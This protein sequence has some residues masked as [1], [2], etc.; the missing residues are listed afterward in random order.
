MI[1]PIE[2]KVTPDILNYSEAMKNGK[3]RQFR[4]R[5][6]ELACWWLRMRTDVWREWTEGWNVK[7]EIIIGGMFTFTGTEEF[8][9]LTPIKEP[10]NVSL[11]SLFPVTPLLLDQKLINLNNQ[12]QLMEMATPVYVDDRIK[13]DNDPE[14]LDGRLG[15]SEPPDPEL[16]SFSADAFHAVDQLNGDEAYLGNSEFAIKLQIRNLT[17]S[18][19]VVL[20]DF[21]NFLTVN[22]NNESILGVVHTHTHNEPSVSL[23]RNPAFKLL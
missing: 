6:R 17:C 23:R 14:R 4:V 12:L 18:Q 20:N 19:N 15:S 1:T 16:S 7:K 5:Y 21:F 2:K 9:D 8:N 13:N 3:E 22:P 10:I 11:S